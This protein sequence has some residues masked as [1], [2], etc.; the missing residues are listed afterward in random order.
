MARIK[1]NYVLPNKMDLPRR[2]DSFTIARMVAKLIEGPE[3]AAPELVEGGG[4]RALST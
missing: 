3:A 1:L 2:W 4:K